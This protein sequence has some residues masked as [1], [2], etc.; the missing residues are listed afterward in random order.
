MYCAYLRIAGR[1]VRAEAFLCGNVSPTV[2]LCVIC[3]LYNVNVHIHMYAHTHTHART[4]YTHS[5]CACRHTYAHAW[6]IVGHAFHATSPPPSNYHPHCCPPTLTPP[7]RLHPSTHLTFAPHP[8]TLP[9]PPLPPCSH[10]EEGGSSKLAVPTL[11]L[12]MDEILK[13]AMKKRQLPLS[14]ARQC[15]Q[16]LGLCTVL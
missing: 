7:P 8:I 6:H 4:T 10:Y 12:G 15:V 1:S 14:T 9:S 5:T 13:S 11:D 3:V 2:L 16:L